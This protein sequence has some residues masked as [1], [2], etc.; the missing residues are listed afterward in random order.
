MKLKYNIHRLCFIL[1]F[2]AFN[3]ISLTISQ[4][5]CTSR[6]ACLRS[7][8]DKTMATTAVANRY[9]ITENTVRPLLYAYSR[10]DFIIW[11]E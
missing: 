8:P 9:Q 2:L 1:I 7:I 11:T 6:I 5:I 3:L 4:E 10:M